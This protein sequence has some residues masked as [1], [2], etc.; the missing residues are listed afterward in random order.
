[1]TSLASDP[2]AHGS[3]A[4]YCFISEYVRF[5]DLYCI[6]GGE[7]EDD[8]AEVRSLECQLVEFS[9]RVVDEC[10]T[11]VKRV[12]SAWLIWRS[13][14]ERGWGGRQAGGLSQRRR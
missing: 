9:P 1:M 12:R 13:P 5:T 14:Q 10:R 2:C 4:Y 7:I 3:G 11:V 8:D 6:S